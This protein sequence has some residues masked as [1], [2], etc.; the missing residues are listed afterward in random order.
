MILSGGIK[1]LA[2]SVSAAQAAPPAFTE[3]RENPRSRK[4]EEER[5]QCVCAR[6]R[7]CLRREEERGAELSSSQRCAA[8]PGTFSGLRVVNH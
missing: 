3:T 4:S 6:V 2:K 1:S 5:V 7:V 8:G